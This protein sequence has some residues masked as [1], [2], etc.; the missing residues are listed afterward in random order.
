MLGCPGL[1]GERPGAEPRAFHSLPLLAISRVVKGVAA[2][3][4]AGNCEQSR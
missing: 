2:G 1:A 3:T 4:S